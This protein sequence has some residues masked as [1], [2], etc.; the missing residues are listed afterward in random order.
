MFL[1]RKIKDEYKIIFVGESG[2]GAKSTLIK[3]LIGKIFTL[4]IETTSRCSFNDLKIE[5]KKEKEITLHL[6]DIIGQE[7]MRPM[8]K[9]FIRDPDCIVIGYDITNRLSF[10]EAKG[11][12]YHMVKEE[13]L[14]N[15]IY[16]VANKIDL[17]NQEEVETEEATE[18]AKKENVRFFEISCKTDEGIK[19]FF[20]DLVLNLI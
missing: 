8:T 9:L 13:K 4:N 2:I 3:R 19:E 20:D 17:Y 11:F 16:F 5:L 15:L 6:W 7:T 12:W 18:F 1:Y 14:C 10:E